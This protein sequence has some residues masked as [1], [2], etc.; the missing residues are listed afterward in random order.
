M[1][2][3]LMMFVLPEEALGYTGLRVRDKQTG[4]V[5][6][7]E[8]S[9]MW[10]PSEERERSIREHGDEA[11]WQIEVP[12]RAIW[13]P[14]EE[15]RPEHGRDWHWDK[16]LLDAHRE[17]VRMSLESFLN[18]NL[19]KLDG[20]VRTGWFIVDRARARV[21]ELRERAHHK[22]E[23]R[24]ARARANARRRAKPKKRRNSPA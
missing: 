13:E 4:E 6:E 23:K 8:R 3:V 12:F 5:R 18:D 17:R 19:S 22:G 16:T 10:I 11:F 20:M 15:R 7:L 14:P 9:R 2:D 1:G 24:M 21:S